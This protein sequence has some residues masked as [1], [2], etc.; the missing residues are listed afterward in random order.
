[1]RNILFLTSKY[2]TELMGVCIL[3][4]MLF[5]SGVDAPANFVL[6]A[7]WYVFI[8]FGG[9]FGV[10][11]FFMLSGYGLIYSVLSKGDSQ[12]WS[13]YFKKRFI[14]ILPAYIIVASCYYAIICENA[15]EFFYN[16]SFLN[17]V[18]DGQ[19]DFWYIF[20]IIVFYMLFPL[21]VQLLRRLNI[22]LS[23]LILI[24][25]WQI[26]CCMLDRFYPVVYSNL[27][28]MLQRFPCFCIG[29]YMGYQAVERRNGFWVLVFACT[30]AGL[31]MMFSGISFTGISRWI[32][33]TMSLP[34]ICILVLIID[35]PYARFVSKCLKWCGKR[36]LELY[37]VHV[38]FGIFLMD[39]LPNRTFSLIVYFLGSFLL[40]LVLHRYIDMI[41]CISRSKEIVS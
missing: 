3:W 10:D 21:I 33:T 14:R 25:L 18:F 4:I 22:S 15:A 19:R 8:S 35:I 29:I 9:G 16:L 13:R 12:S 40:A 24:V 38:S 23:M 30:L 6:R 2:R 11:I 32:F 26:A 39:I 36:S 28:I 34:V 27:K 20:A 17:F 31:W 41:N 37:L 7:L 5:H 1:M